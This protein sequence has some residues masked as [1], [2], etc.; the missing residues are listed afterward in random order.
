MSR[1]GFVFDITTTDSDHK[2]V[3][4][5]RNCRSEQDGSGLAQPALFIRIKDHLRD[6]HALTDQ[7]GWKLTHQ[8]RTP[9]QAVVCVWPPEAL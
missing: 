1:P 6:K 2:T 8:E 9:T 4:V 3:C 7:D 5:C